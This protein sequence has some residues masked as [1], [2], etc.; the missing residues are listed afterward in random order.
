MTGAEKEAGI[1]V[2]NPAEEVRRQRPD[3][4]A[5]YSVPQDRQSPGAAVG[6]PSQA[7][8]KDSASKPTV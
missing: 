4:G 2:G 7:C 3:V 8:T 6:K 1:P 5:S